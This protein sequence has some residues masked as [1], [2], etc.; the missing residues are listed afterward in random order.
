MCMAPT[1][2]AP[3]AFHRTVLPAASHCSLLIQCIA[4]YGIY[5]T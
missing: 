5:C 3:L 2:C 1:C 4:S